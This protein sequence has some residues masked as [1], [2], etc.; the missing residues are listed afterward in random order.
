MVCD[1]VIL[2]ALRDVRVNSLLLVGSG[3]DISSLN[4]DHTPN[5]HHIN[6]SFN[7]IIK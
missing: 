5:F 7:K 6:P 4:V 3:N 1:V 2:A